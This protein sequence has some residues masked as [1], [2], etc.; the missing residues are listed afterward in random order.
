MYGYYGRGPPKACPPVTFK[1]LCR[2]GGRC[3]A[4]RD[5]NVVLAPSNP[6]DEHQ[7]WSKDVRF[8]RIV[9]DEEGNPAFSLVNKATGLAIKHSLGHG[10]PV[11]LARFMPGEDYPDE[12]VLWTESCDVCRDFGRIRMLYNVDLNLDASPDGSTAVLSDSELAGVESQTWIMI[13]SDGAYVGRELLP[14]DE[15]TCRIYCK[16]KEGLSAT[17]RDGAVCLAP[18]DRHDIHQHWIV[19][20]RPGDVIKD[21]DGDAAF[22]LVTR[23]TGE[24]IGG[25]VSEFKLM[26]KPY[27]PNY[28]D[29][30][31]LWSKSADMGDGF[32]LIHMVDNFTLNFDAFKGDKDHSGMLSSSSIGLSPWSWSESDGDNLKWKIDPWV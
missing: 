3:L 28:L 16:A 26:L 21:V 4:V 13:R 6:G 10:H 2:A 7:L 1:I 23:L 22:A 17:V 18:T 20:K 27:N 11:R 9:K 31:I 12:S 24:A 8:S 32:R 15:Q 30:W 25:S 19:D 14:A 5:G 29:K